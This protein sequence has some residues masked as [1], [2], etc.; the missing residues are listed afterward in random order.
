MLRP[1]FALLLFVS[2][3]SSCLASTQNTASSQPHK[4]YISDNLYTYSRS[5]PGEEFRLITRLKAGEQV[6]ITN[7]TQN[8]F[9]EIIDHNKRHSWVNSKFITT[10]E[11]FRYQIQQLEQAKKAAETTAQQ[12]LSTAKNM[13]HD[14]IQK[15]EML[16]TQLQTATV[17]LQQLN[18]TL[19]MNR[20]VLN[21]TEQQL[22]ALQGRQHTQ[23]WLQGGLIAGLGLVLGLIIPYLP[24]PRQRKPKR[25][26]S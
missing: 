25:W 5:G 23:M 11:T 2:A 24:S 15:K 8:N 3:Y 18:N 19:N 9:T 14:L 22:H 7:N 6:Q 21:D 10:K 12:A 26:M 13:H 17:N 1:I 4:G 20:K 16:T